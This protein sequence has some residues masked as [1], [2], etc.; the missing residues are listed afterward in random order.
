MVDDKIR[1]G[2]QAAHR[3]IVPL[4]LRSGPSRITDPVLVPDELD[5]TRTADAD[6]F[7]GERWLRAADEVENIAAEIIAAESIAQRKQFHCATMDEPVRV[8]DSAESQDRLHS[9]AAEDLRVLFPRS[10]ATRP[11]GQHAQDIAQAAHRAGNNV[12]DRHR[13]ES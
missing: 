2:A 6:E 1:K 13:S 4:R 5:S 9:L 7:F 12:V 3:R 8:E 10:A 11:P